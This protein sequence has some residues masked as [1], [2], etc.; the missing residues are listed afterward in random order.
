MSPKYD[1]LRKCKEA[2]VIAYARKHRRGQPDDLSLKEIGQKFG[3]SASR[4]WQILRKAKLE[5][6]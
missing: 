3:I 2:D 1:S 4:V 6:P 5:K